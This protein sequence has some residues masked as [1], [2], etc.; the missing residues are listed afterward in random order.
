MEINKKKFPIYLSLFIVFSIVI[1]GIV[2]LLQDKIDKIEIKKSEKLITE[3]PKVVNTCMFAQRNGSIDLFEYTDSKSISDTLMYYY[4]CYD[5]STSDNWSIIDK[6]IY[7]HLT[8]SELTLDNLDERVNI[9]YFYSLI[10]DKYNIKGQENIKDYLLTIKH[11]IKAQPEK[12][13]YFLNLLYKTRECLNLL[14]LNKGSDIL[15]PYITNIKIDNNDLLSQLSFNTIKVAV[16]GER[17]DVLEVLE[18]LKSNYTAKKI[19]LESFIIYINNLPKEYI[20]ILPKSY[21]NKIY[22][23]CIENYY[24][25]SPY[26]S[27]IGLRICQLYSDINSKEIIKIYKSKPINNEG[28]VPALAKIIPTYRRLFHFREL[29]HLLGVTIDKATIYEISDSI[30][31]DKIM[32]ED[33]YY[34]TILSRDCPDIKVDKQQLKA[35]IKNADNTEITTANLFAFYFLIKSGLMN[36]INCDKLILKVN[37]FINSCNEKYL[38]AD[39]WK[40]ELN[41]LADKKD[42]YSDELEQKVLSYNGDSEIEVLYYYILYHNTINKKCSNE[43]K[44]KINTSVNS[45]YTELGNLGGFWSNSEFKYIDITTTY[46]CLFLKD[47]CN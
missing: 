7:T 35:V 31:K 36:N 12:N 4:F 43:I 9:I 28:F 15:E 47:F 22:D 39:I 16:N 29:S 37:T 33:Y 41:Y 27:F 42:D 13:V 20:K 40:A 1:V 21:I 11:F 3:Y 30:D 44:K 6:F 34:M 38:I 2:T 32:T 23:L 19:D 5:S 17:N 18:N 24:D 46:E 25:I 10:I 14:G 45:H 8:E 26:T